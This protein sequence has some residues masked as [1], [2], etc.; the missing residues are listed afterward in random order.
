MKLIE[1]IEKITD[2]CIK[3][4]FCESVCPTLEPSGFD[5]IFGARGRVI[6]ADYTVKHMDEPLT[7]S[8]AFYS[9]LDCYACVNVCPSGVNAGIVSELMKE[10]VTE[11]RA[12]SK[13]PIAEIVKS[14]I[15][16]YENPLGLKYE[17]AL[18]ADG[19]KFDGNETII[20]TGDMYQ[21]MPYTRFINKIRK[22][23]SE[24]TVNSLA[25]SLSYHLPLIKLSRHFYDSGIRKKMEKDLRNIVFM[26][27]E[28]GIKF[29]YLGVDEPYPGMFL[30][31]LGYQKEFTAY[32]RKVYSKF[33]ALG[34]K[35]IIALD[36]HTYDLLK[37]DYP[38]A[39]KNFNI[40]IVYYSDLINLKYKKYNGKITVQ[41]P[42]HM[43]L[44]NNNYNAI[45]L[46]GSV[47]DISMP[48]RNGKNTMC[49]GGPD[50]LL[51]P[52]TGQKIAEERY[53][54]LKKKADKIV[55]ICPLCYNSLSHGDDV[56]D[57]SEFMSSLIIKS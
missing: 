48:D 28:S 34:V 57:F 54:Q 53:M 33:K 8:D 7:V 22:F 24:E 14:A 10:L 38:E 4:G 35:Q 42:C 26:L 16:A 1:S 47:A 6:L 56:E 50:E 49:C 23:I 45:G 5:S 40:N 52:A 36:P 15:I 19:I 39:V 13:N 30:H 11:N 12:K 17:S 51:F 2:K 25:I 29:G 32:A 46:L 9:C 21:L 55:T 3:C 27:K 18:W 31:D 20:L 44:H 37:N 43:A 41:E